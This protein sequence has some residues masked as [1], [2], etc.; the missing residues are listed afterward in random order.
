MNDMVS[1]MVPVFKSYGVKKASLFGSHARGEA[2]PESDVD[3]LV[4]FDK[5]RSMDLFKYIK[6][7]QD[8][9]EKVGKKVDVV[10]YSTIKPLLRESIMEDEK[11]IYLQK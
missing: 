4:E 10:Q 3:V 7:G 2:K 6:F 5:T 8:L 11:L 1:K 9:T